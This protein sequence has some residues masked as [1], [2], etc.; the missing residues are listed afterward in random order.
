MQHATQEEA[1]QVVAGAALQRAAA[2]EALLTAQ[3]AATELPFGDTFHVKDL[4][5][6]VSTRMLR[7]RMASQCARANV[8]EVL[9]LK[10]GGWSKM[11]T[12]MKYVETGDPFATASVNLTSVCLLGQSAIPTHGPVELSG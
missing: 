3:A 9:M 8:G 11:K 10:T 1:A 7:R 6:I 2:E 5:G 4:C 12:A